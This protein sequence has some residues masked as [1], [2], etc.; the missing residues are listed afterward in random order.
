MPSPNNKQR[1]EGEME[2]GTEGGKDRKKERRNSAL[3]ISQKCTIF[4]ELDS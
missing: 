4:F 3:L 2:R 1:R